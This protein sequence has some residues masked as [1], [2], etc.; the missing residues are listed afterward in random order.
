[1]ANTIYS[2]LYNAVNFHALE[3]AA[4][5]GLAAHKAEDTDG[6][7]V[8]AAAY[9]DAFNLL[10]DSIVARLDA[11]YLRDFRAATEDADNTIRQ[12]FALAYLAGVNDARMDVAEDYVHGIGDTCEEY[13]DTPD[14]L[15]STVTNPIIDSI[16][17]QSH[18]KMPRGIVSAVVRSIVDN[19]DE[20]AGNGRNPF[21]PDSAT[22]ITARDGLQLLTAHSEPTDEEQI[23]SRDK[24]TLSFLR[25]LV[26]VHKSGLI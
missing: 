3:D 20:D 16:A 9:E 19:F 5:A 8:Q 14:L 18:D 24:A 2:L 7:A 1:M 15:T 13:P 25:Q 12:M 6:E 4:A 11:R 23:A 10:T 22:F 26:E 21:L 17:N